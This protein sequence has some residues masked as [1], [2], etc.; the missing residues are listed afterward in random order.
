MMET[1]RVLVVEDS[2]DD[3][4]VL[5]RRLRLDQFDASCRRV[6][7]ADGLRAALAEGEWD[8][9]ITDY[10]MPQMTGTDLAEQILQIRPDIPIILCTGFSERINEEGAK[11]AGICAFLMK[12]GNRRDIALLVRKVLKTR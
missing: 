3:L 6:D 11:K 9:V 10:T 12:P 2:E 8:L 4:L 7:S 1:L 5:K